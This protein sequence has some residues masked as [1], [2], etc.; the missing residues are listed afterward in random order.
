MLR[1]LVLCLTIVAAFHT[2]LAAAPLVTQATVSA[3]VSELAERLGMNVAR[4]RG[5]FVPEII[6]RIYSPPPTRQIT[7][8]LLPLPGRTPGAAPV[9]AAARPAPGTQTQVD[10]PL[11]LAFW[12]EHI[13]KR[14]IPPDQWLAWVLSE[15]RAALV[16]RGLLGADDE[17]L[18]FY[19]AHP[20]LVAF[21]YEH[22]P[23]AFAAIAD[24][25]HVHDGRVRVAG[26][27]VAEGLWQGLLHVP[28]SEPDAFIRALL[29]E[30]EA[31]LAYLFDALEIAAPASRAFALGTWIDDE[32]LRTQRFQALGR[33]RRFG[34]RGRGRALLRGQTPQDFA[35]ARR[36]RIR[37]VRTQLSALLLKTGA[38]RQQDLVA[39][40]ARLLLLAP[41]KLQNQ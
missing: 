41:D 8:T 4:D 30:P 38:A 16:C 26:G 39:L 11:T 7:L 28:A 15:R 14:Q 12:S 37:T 31:R 9:A 17:T 25:I 13:F 3:P 1:A 24:S 34:G 22:A 6:R 40:V 29:F 36:V 19:E 21:I 10:M 20:G 32:A 33:T 27:Q 5:R 35:D 23:G 2:P 18:A